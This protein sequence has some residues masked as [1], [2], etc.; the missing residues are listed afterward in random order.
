[1]A[2]TLRP[3][4]FTSF[5]GHKKWLGEEILKFF[6]FDPTKCK[7]E[8][9]EFGLHI[10]QDGCDSLILSYGLEITEAKETQ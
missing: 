9:K 5:D 10:T 1:M 8:V 2:R 4:E 3:N 7:I 6:N